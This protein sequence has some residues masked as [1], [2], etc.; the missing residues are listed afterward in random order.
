MLS[1]FNKLSKRKKVLALT[2]AAS[3]AAA[4]A[5]AYWTTTGSGSGS[6]S[7]GTDTART[8]TGTIDDALVPGGSSNVTLTADKDAHTSYKIGAITGTV[9]VTN[10]YNVTT[11]P[12]GC[13][14]S[15][16]TFTGPSGDQTVPAGTGS[17]TLTS[18]SI[19][20][21]NSSS[22]QDGCKNQTVSIDLSAAA[23]ASP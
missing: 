16:F 10:P 22:N 2:V 20:M 18:G 3:M 9:T 19:S 1:L 5:F 14:A 13:K 4:V 12:T 15:D 8:I 23:P 21:S 6:G 17:Y 7:V 11:N